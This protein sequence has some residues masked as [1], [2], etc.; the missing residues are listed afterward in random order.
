MRGKSKTIIL[1]TVVMFLSSCNRL[2]TLSND[3]VI[4]EVKKCEAA[5]MKAVIMHQYNNDMKND[6]GAARV[7]CEMKK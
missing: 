3:Q 6:L 1:L 4:A 2:P 7:D 5:G